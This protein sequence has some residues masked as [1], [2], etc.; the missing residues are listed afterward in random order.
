MSPE[1]TQRTPDAGT[2]GLTEGIPVKTSLFLLLAGVLIAAV[3]AVF[4]AAFSRQ[5][6]QAAHTILD[7]S[8]EF[9]QQALQVEV[10][11][12]RYL[13]SGDRK[14]LNDYEDAVENSRK[15]GKKLA[16]ASESIYFG[17]VTLAPAVRDATSKLETWF[18]SFSGPAIEL[19]RAKE[20][21]KLS[22]LIRK[23]S[24]TA[25][26]LAL[27]D[28]VT[29]LRA[30]TTASLKQGAGRALLLERVA[31][32]FMFAGLVMLAF[33]G[34]ALYRRIRTLL[35]SLKS[36]SEALELLAHWSERIQHSYSDD[37]AV[38]TLANHVTK[39]LGMSRTT[40]LL[41]EPV[42]QE[43]RVAADIRTR[44][45]VP[46]AEGK[47]AS[48]CPVLTTGQPIFCEH[49]DGINPCA[50]CALNQNIRGGYLCVPL[51]AQGSVVGVVRSE[52]PD[53]KPLKP[54][55]VQRIESLVRLTSITLNTLL[56][57][58]EAK[59]QA[60]TDGLTEVFNRRF[61]DVFL[62]KQVQVANRSKHNLAVL[63]MDLDRFKDFNDRFGHAAGDALL[64]AFSM[65][66]SRVVR[67][68]DLLARYG[69]E[70]F[71]IVLPDTDKQ[72]AVV[73][74]ERV[75]EAALSIRLDILPNL[76]APVMTVSIGVACLPENGTT[77]VSL[78][79]A[80]DKALYHAKESGRNRVETA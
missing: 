26:S 4:Y 76:P 14:S 34:L 74:G 42:T 77:V 36:H 49:S 69:G 12:Q 29:S 68:G 78:M 30:H 50:N 2:P 63:M 33:A 70:E 17:S 3:S 66:L 47:D 41:R 21:Q 53:G 23:S 43:L 8:S 10:S 25:A 27:R 11:C 62:Q 79:Q 18:G 55:T 37:Q 80:A 67:D 9:A 45:D 61:L 64:R 75:R 73:M 22:G 44:E 32:A 35:E 28:A 13:M 48:L 15:T 65:A 7:L 59:Q 38:A 1:L 16:A 6:T 72:E 20:S 46:P 54:T 60:T 19:K 40:V 51:T 58:G 57:L 39:K 5:T 52:G 24:S 31:L 71:T 56:S